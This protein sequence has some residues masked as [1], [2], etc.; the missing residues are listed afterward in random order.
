MFSIRTVL[1]ATLTVAILITCWNLVRESRS[2][3]VRG[4]PKEIADSLIP[5]ISKG[6]HY[7]KPPNTPAEYIWLFAAYNNGRKEINVLVEKD[8]G[9]VR[10]RAFW[11]NYDSKLWC[12]DVNLSGAQWDTIM[13]ILENEHALKL[14]NLVPRVSHA[15][16][17]R[18]KLRLRNEEHESCAYGIEYTDLFRTEQFYAEEWQRVVYGL[19]SFR[20]KF[21][22]EIR[23]ADFVTDGMVD[24]N[25][26]RKSDANLSEKLVDLPL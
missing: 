9:I 13:S 19:L 1:Y 25:S 3:I 8:A 7:L 14:P 6:G 23:S 18:L 17:Y 15:M 21:P 12:L 16:T 2:N 4:N 20:E 10:Y 24:W 11:L 22:D 5:P 26:A